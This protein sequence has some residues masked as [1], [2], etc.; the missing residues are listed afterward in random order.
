MFYQVILLGARQ[1]SCLKVREAIN[2]GQMDLFGHTDYVRFFD[3]SLDSLY[4]DF[5][6]MAIYAGSEEAR[7]NDLFRAELKHCLECNY[8]VL[9]IFS[10]EDFHREIPDLIK[11]YNGLSKLAVQEWPYRAASAVMEA[12]GLIR[13]KRKVFIS[14]K[15][16]DSAAIAT[17]LCES[18]NSL[19]YQVFLDTYRIHEGK[20]FQQELMHWLS[21]SDMLI[22]LDS[23]NI[24]LS[25]WVER[26]ISAA[27]SLGIGCIQ[28]LWPGRKPRVDEPFM[29]TITLPGKPARRLK[30]E[31]LKK[32]VTEVEKYRALCIGTRLRALIGNFERKMSARD[33][34][35]SW[36]K[37]RLLKAEHPSGKK[38][39]ILPVLGVP[40]SEDI[41]SGSCFLNNHGAPDDD[42]HLLFE[43]RQVLPAHIEHL[44]WLLKRVT[45]H[46]LCTS[47]LPDLLE[48]DRP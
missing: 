41:Y 14:Y 47:S 39:T 18:L 4:P 30:P 13:A 12:F 36:D 5:P 2:Q 26:E 8:P 25:S 7:K 42:F 37:G 19:R 32:A 20:N 38:A 34:K 31:V 35:V 11:H 6:A 23:D 15:R 21:D 44:D 16:D 48:K 29:H 33:W 9:P 17:Q 1:E 10:G 24:D 3:D 22:L 46:E 43:P 28:I 27:V 45:R 40:D